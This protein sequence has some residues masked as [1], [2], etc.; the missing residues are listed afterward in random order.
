MPNRLQR[1]DDRRLNLQQQKTRAKEL[2]NAVRRG[3]AAALARVSLHHPEAQSL[4]GEEI[5]AKLTRLSDAQLTI[6]R[7][8]GLPNWPKLKEHIESL[9]R[10]RRAIAGKGPAPDGD[11][12]T[13]HCRCGSDIKARLA[14]GGFVGEF[15]EFSDPLWL[16]PLAHNGSDFESRAQTISLAGEHDPA[17]VA[18]KLRREHEALTGA[19]ELY[20]RIALWCEHDPYDQLCLARVLA[21]FSGQSRIP[22]LELIA[23]DRFPAI[24]RFIG[25]GQLSA[26]ALRS[27]WDNRTPSNCS[28]CRPTSCFRS[29]RRLT[30]CRVRRAHDSNSVVFGRYI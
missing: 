16:G 19:A 28:L 10:A 27:L 20:S 13:A 4:S 2:C 17:D 21:E 9:D 26:A 15:L 6:A 22:Q 3:D 29:S 14:E 24:E 1:D 7:E 11:L 12:T 18:A 5:S 25:L 8:L 30:L 23:L